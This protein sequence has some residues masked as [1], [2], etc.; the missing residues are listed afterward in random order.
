MARQRI[1][2]ELGRPETPAETAARK[3]AASQR[4]RSSKTFRNLIAALIV[5]VGIMAVVY[6]GV[7][8]GTPADVP[9]ADVAASA[10]QA[11]KV[12]GHGVV[13]PDVPDAWRA[14][15][16]LVEGGEWRI[17]YAPARGYVEVTQSFSAP[18][19]WVSRELGGFAPTGT[20]TIDAVDWDVYELPSPV[21]QI[22]YALATTIG[23][24]T[25]IIGLSESTDRSAAATVAESLGDQI[26]TLREEA[27]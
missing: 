11:E 5:C 16:A 13:I 24:D 23:S 3:A 20:T 25:V 22:D 17:V 7:P 4:Y 21:Q 15:S 6:L 2:A 10:A 1:V 12:A 26:R 27:R 9:E 19:G 18:D 14:N 8:R